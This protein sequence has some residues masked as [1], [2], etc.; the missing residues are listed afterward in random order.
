MDHVKAPLAEPRRQKRRDRHIR[1]EGF[2]SLNNQIL[3]RRLI[4]LQSDPLEITLENDFDPPSCGLFQK[5]K[6]K[7]QHQFAVFILRK[8]SRCSEQIRFLVFHPFYNFGPRKT[9]LNALCFFSLGQ[10]DKETAFFIEETDA[11]D[12][13]GKVVVE[14]LQRQRKHADMRVFHFIFFSVQ[15]LRHIDLTRCSAVP[16]PRCSPLPAAAQDSSRCLF[17]ALQI[18]AGLHQLLICHRA[19]RLA[20]FQLCTK[21]HAE[22]L[23]HNVE[24]LTRLEQLVAAR[25]RHNH[26]AGIRITEHVLPQHAIERKAARPLLHPDL[27]TIAIFSHLF[28]RCRMNGGGRCDPFRRDDLFSFEFSAVHVHHPELGRVLRAQEEAPAAFRNPC[29]AALPENFPDAERL[30]QTRPQV[31]YHFHAGALLYD[32]RQQIRVHTVVLKRFARRSLDRRI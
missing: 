14:D 28:R 30:K 16:R 20:G 5:C 27:V 18:T 24:H 13:V 25:I 17:R 1:H 23:P 4:P 15:K 26:H 8:L 11:A 21:F 31:I 9:D 7:L 6:L 32:C 3:A 10:L 22:I 19:F 12:A 29:R 2:K